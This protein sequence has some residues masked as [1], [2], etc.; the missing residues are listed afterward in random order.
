MD[1]KRFQEISLYYPFK[2]ISFLISSMSIWIIVCNIMSK[3]MLDEAERNLVKKMSVCIMASTLQRDSQI[4]PF[5]VLLIF[6]MFVFLNYDD[7]MDIFL[8]MHNTV[9]LYRYLLY[10][11]ICVCM[12]VRIKENGTK[13]NYPSYEMEIK[14]F[15]MFVL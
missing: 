10:D 13:R 3:T 11:T 8:F 4:T 14:A 12:V 9:Q 2:E 15:R 7:F 1:W 6:K 5:V